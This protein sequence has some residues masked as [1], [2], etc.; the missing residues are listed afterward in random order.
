MIR[1]TMLVS[2]AALVLTL[3]AG[4]DKAADDQAKANNAQAE[5]NKTAAEA[6][7]QS[8]TKTTGAQVEADKKIASAEQDFAKRRED[9]RHSVASDLVDVEK[10][11]Y[12]AT[13]KDKTL[14][15]NKKVDMDATLTSIRAQR[16]SFDQDVKAIDSSTALQFDSLKDKT[17]KDLSNLKSLVDKAD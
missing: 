1:S 14:A 2:A 10:K 7:Q 5:A 16:A 8:T 11:I 17:D 12:T 6:N 4:C 3:G 13:A 15:G 9:Y